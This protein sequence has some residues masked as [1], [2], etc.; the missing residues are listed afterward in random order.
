MAN[1]TS[2]PPEPIEFETLYSPPQNK[3]HEIVIMGA[4]GQRIVTAG[5][6]L[7]MAGVTAGL[8]TTQK[9]DYPITV[10]RGH[11]V[12]EVILSPEKVDFT[13]IEN[14][15]VLIALAEEGVNRKKISF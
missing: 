12:T 4:A 11:S 9:N 6:L 8:Y 14:P 10:M 7:C 15:T 3:R 1:N 13:G 5:E 2:S